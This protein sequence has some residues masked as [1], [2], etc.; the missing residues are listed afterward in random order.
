MLLIICVLAMAKGYAQEIPVDTWY[1]GI[2]LTQP[3]TY[4]MTN[5]ITCGLFPR[6]GIEIAAS[7]ITLNMQGHFIVGQCNGDNW[8]VGVRVDDGLN[9]VV[10]KGPGT[11]RETCGGVK[12]SAGGQQNTVTHVHIQ[13][14]SYPGAI[15]ISHSNS[16]TVRLNTI[17]NVSLW[18][19]VGQA[20]TGGQITQNTITDNTAT[21]IELWQAGN[22][23]ILGNT[24]V[25]NSSG[26]IVHPTT[27]RSWVTIESNDTSSNQTYGIYASGGGTIANN[28]VNAN[29]DG[30][31]VDG[32]GFLIQSNTANSSRH[33]GIAITKTY[34]P[35]PINNTIKSNDAI[36]NGT[37]DLYWDGN[38]TGNTWSQ[39]NC[40]TWSV[41]IGPGPCIAP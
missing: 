18:G 8:S 25:R 9:S 5:D 21:A 22:V 29:Q 15:D 13:N 4:N 7:G 23:A 41:S 17:Q 26:I 14:T 24:L 28:S 19:I 20:F 37:L 30:I 39:N 2:K 34:G 3:G 12:L 40:D 10:I 16:S 11:I 35:P 38:G 33:Y 1:C 32:G 27:P 36:G 6:S 31:Y